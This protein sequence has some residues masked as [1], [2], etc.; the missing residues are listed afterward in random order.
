M[1]IKRIE[2]PA[3]IPS[4]IKTSFRANEFIFLDIDSRTRSKTSI[5]SSVD[6]ADKQNSFC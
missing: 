5:F 2:Q 6:S 1:N 4:G 3:S